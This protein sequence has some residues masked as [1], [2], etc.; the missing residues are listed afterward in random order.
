MNEYFDDYIKISQLIFSIS[1]ID[2][3][4]Y[5]QKANEKLQLLNHS[6]PTLIDSPENEIL[7]VNLQVSQNPVDCYY[8]YRNS[9]GLEYIAVGLWKSEVFWGSIVIGPFISTTSILELIKEIIY[10]NNLPIS[11]R[12]RLEDFYHS[13]PVLTETEYGCMG[14]L[15]VNLCRHPL[16]GAKEISTD[17]IQPVL[18]QK[19][20][21]NLIEEEKQVI[22]DRYEQ[23]NKLMDAITRGDKEEVHLLL[24][25]AENILEFSNRFPESPIRAAKNIAF[26]SNTLFRVAARR[27]GV[28]PVY[29]HN[30]SER[31]A[32]LIERTSN[33][34]S[35]K[36][37]I[38]L[39][40]SEYCDLVRTYATG[41]YSPIV[42]KTVEYIQ[43]NL[44][45]PLSLKQIAEKIYA[46]PSLLSRKFKEETGVG[47]TDFI[48]EKRI[49]EAKLYLQ[50]GYGS[51]TDI[52]FMVGFND[53]NYFSKVFKKITGVTPSQYIKR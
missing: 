40:A 7:Q 13:L 33:I 24:L 45:K 30:L 32:I 27:S 35:L 19:E 31:F 26:A 3:R 51:I 22:E 17:I 12:K 10:K 34:P 25:T 6:I 23:E 47:I 5:D 4:L 1:K 21:E 52:A 37:L 36:K 41:K 49:N 2:V 11:Q 42:S 44:S 18:N 14:E 48:N 20:L 46:N 53:L 29:L 38:T 43:L 28:H 15:L 16:K 8:H 50:R 9:F 39:M